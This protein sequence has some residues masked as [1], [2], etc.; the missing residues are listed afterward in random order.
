M[1]ILLLK[2]VPGLGR[3]SD[4]KNV[5]D[6]YASNFLFPR[7]LAKAAN[8]ATEKQVMAERE[9]SRLEQ[10]VRDDLLQKNL[11]S[12]SGVRVVIKGKANEQGHLFAGIH[13]NEIS[14]ALKKQHGLDI[15]AESIELQEPIK[16]VGEYDISV[17]A[18]GKMES[19]KL[20]VEPFSE[21]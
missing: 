5:A 19:L 11:K 14:Q 9:K 2:D 10:A 12:L 17:S 4:I 13:Q 21:R 15:S 16:A 3:K 8:A 1:K 18:L 7:G 20:S 6:G